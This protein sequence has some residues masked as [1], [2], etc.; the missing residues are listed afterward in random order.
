VPRGRW[1]AAQNVSVSFE[2]VGPIHDIAT[3]AMGRRIRGLPR[4][5]K[6]YGQ[7]RWRKMNGRAGVRLLDGRVLEAEVHWYEATG[8][9]R[10]ELKFKRPLDDKL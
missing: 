10:K 5:V 9:G 3:I 8:V 7:G 1:K 4:L 2:L 6:L